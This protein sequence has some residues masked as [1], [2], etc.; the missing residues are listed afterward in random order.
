MT[1]GESS[2]SINIHN[3][4]FWFLSDNNEPYVIINNN[5]DNHILPMLLVKQNDKSF[6]NEG[7]GI[8]VIIP[9]DIDLLWSN[10]LF[11]RS[12]V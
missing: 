12:L 3:I 6:I 8:N 2:K 7:D 11:L 10:N 1:A 9:E 4:D 5:K